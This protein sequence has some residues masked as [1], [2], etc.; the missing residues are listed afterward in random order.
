MNNES[1]LRNPFTY[2]DGLTTLTANDYRCN[3]EIDECIK[4]LREELSLEKVEATKVSVTEND[5]ISA[6]QGVSGFSVK[7]FS[8]FIDKGRNGND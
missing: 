6:S 2:L 5:W 4:A 3:K 7:G 8:G 1:R